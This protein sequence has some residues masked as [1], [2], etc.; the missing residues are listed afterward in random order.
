MRAI[1]IRRG[2]VIIILITFFG[3]SVNA[4]DCN[5]YS[6]DISGEEWT[7]TL[8]ENLAEKYPIDQLCGLVEPDDWYVNAKF[9]PCTPRD[10]L[11]DSFDW[12]DEVSGGLP[13]VKNQGSCGSCWAFGILK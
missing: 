2:L 10:D 5:K 9:D 7:N 6:E 8:G 12:R 3:A 4:C 13:S 11:P 1:Q